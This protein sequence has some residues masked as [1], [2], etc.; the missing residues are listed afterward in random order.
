MAEKTT[1][2]NARKWVLFILGFVIIAISFQLS[3]T[4]I[5]SNPPPRK[6]AKSTIKDV[7][8]I[9]VKNGPY[10]V[11]I[12]SKGVLQAYK[13]VRITARV[14]GIMQTIN[15]LF[16]SGQEYRSGQT[17]TKIEPSEYRANVI[18]KRA[19]LYNLITSILPDLQ[20]DFPNAYNQ[21]N[22]YLMGFDL[23]KPVPRLPAMQEKIRLF[24]SGRGIISSY[25]SLQNLE[26]TLT[27]YEIKAPF[28]GVLVSAN[29]TEGSLIRPGQELGEFIAPGDYELMVALPKSYVSKIAKGAQVKVKSIDTS[30]IYTGIV[31]RINAKV[32]SKTQS[33]EVY[34]RM[35]DSRLKEGMYMEADINAIEFNN[36]FA[37]DRGLLNETEEIFV[38]QNGK[39]ILKKVNPIHFTET[40]VITRGLNDG[41]QIVAQPLIGAIS[42][43][44]INPIPYNKSK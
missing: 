18:S 9:S 29:V 40:L 24:V 27:F 38:V 42:G 31:S 14:Q 23:E 26:K 39:L 13:R 8:T 32:N 19:S 25:Y 4:I 11:Q 41:E 37:I 17:L 34:I 16:K 5:D 28:N 7:Y 12:P 1:K 3:K 22:K 44:E 20:L 15:P 30:Q 10:Q 35:R 33:V 6:K 2:K 21:W 36:V 43:M